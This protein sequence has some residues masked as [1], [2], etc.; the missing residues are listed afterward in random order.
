MGR[1]RWRS[2]PNRWPGSAGSADSTSGLFASSFLQRLS[3]DY[4][5]SYPSASV[6][7]RLQSG[8]NFFFKMFPSSKI[9]FR[10]FIKNGHWLEKF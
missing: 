4:L 7:I 8:S 6:Q 1:W 10:N 2:P 3:N 9:I 5:V